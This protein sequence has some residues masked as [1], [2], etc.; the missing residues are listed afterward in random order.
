MTP[1]QGRTALN[2]TQNYLVND[3]SKVKP[4]DF[5]ATGTGPLWQGFTGTSWV[6]IYVDAPTSGWY[7]GQ[8]RYANGVSGT[9]AVDSVSVDGQSI[10]TVRLA[11]TGGF[12]LADG[13]IKPY[14]ATLSLTKGDTGSGSP[15]QGVLRSS[16]A[17]I[18]PTPKT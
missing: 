10:G 15:S 7:V 13:A 2:T 8:L 14:D 12:S 17:W 9:D 5:S 3:F 11:P 6:D 1:R 16:T 18:S 4:G